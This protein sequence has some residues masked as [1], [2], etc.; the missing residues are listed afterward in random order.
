MTDRLTD[1]PTDKAGCRVA[2]TRLKKQHDSRTTNVIYHETIIQICD[3]SD[4][5]RSNKKR[6]DDL[7]ES[8]G[9]KEI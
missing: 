4:E 2:C 3:E 1:Q 8:D 9:K 5:K 6:I 7:D